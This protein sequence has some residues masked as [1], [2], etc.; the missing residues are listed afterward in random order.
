M[1]QGGGDRGFRSVTGLSVTHHD[2]RNKC[3]GGWRGST[4]PVSIFILLQKMALQC[5][6]RRLKKLRRRENDKGKCERWICG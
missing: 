1:S 5:F 3:V 4:D 2:V 6:G